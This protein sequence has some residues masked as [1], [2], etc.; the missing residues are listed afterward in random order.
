MFVA[1][2]AVGSLCASVCQRS[3]AEFPGPGQYSEKVEWRLL[4]GLGPVTAAAPQ[5][6]HIVLCVVIVMASSSVKANK[7]A[8]GMPNPGKGGVSAKQHLDAILDSY[9]L[10]VWLILG[11][12]W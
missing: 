6:T 7:E 2:W 11:C 3:T 4:K 10:S 12:I 9:A 8:G 1:N 5:I